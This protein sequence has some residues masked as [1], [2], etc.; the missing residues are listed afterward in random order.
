MLMTVGDYGLIP[1]EAPNKPCGSHYLHDS[2]N[3]IKILN[4]L[5]SLEDICTQT[6]VVSNFDL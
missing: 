4:A 6:Y 2:E 1:S 3:S 5:H